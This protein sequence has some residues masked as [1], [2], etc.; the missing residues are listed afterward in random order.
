MLQEYLTYMYLNF[1]RR[2]NS[3]NT[4]LSTKHTE[5]IKSCKLD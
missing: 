1:H 3:A 2:L 4:N 5:I